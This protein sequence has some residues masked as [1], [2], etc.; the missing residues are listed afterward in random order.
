[1]IRVDW[2]FA[3]GGARSATDGRGFLA[4]DFKKAAALVSPE[5]GSAVRLDR[6]GKLAD[7]VG[8]RGV[9][10]EDNPV[11]GADISVG[12]IPRV[13]SQIKQ[14]EAYCGCADHR[15]EVEISIGDVNRDCAAFRRVAIAAGGVNRLNLLL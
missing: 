13:G 14:F 3:K 6:G 5:D 7:F 9:A 10:R 4:E 15:F 12:I 8:H 2:P 11:G 1:M